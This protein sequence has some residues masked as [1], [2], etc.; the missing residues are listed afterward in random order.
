VKAGAGILDEL[1]SKKLKVDLEEPD[2]EIFVDVRMG[3]VFISRNRIKSS[4]GM[5]LGSQG[6]VVAI[7]SDRDSYTAAW[8]MMRRGC[9]LI[10][11]CNSR[12]GVRTAKRLEEWHIGRKMRVHD[13]SSKRA[14]I[15]KERLFKEAGKIAGER[16]AL[17]IVCGESLCKHQKLAEMVELDA[18]A[19]VPVYRPLVLLG[20]KEVKMVMS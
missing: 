11:V 13:L 1:R 10:A 19:G 16:G 14:K 8:M 6:K 3:Q 9:E 17:G 12:R 5:P 15:S 18:A 20:E 7:V 4:G 2:E